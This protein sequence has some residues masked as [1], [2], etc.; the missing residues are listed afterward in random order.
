VVSNKQRAQK[1]LEWKGFNPA[2]VFED[3]STFGSTWTLEAALKHAVK[4]KVR[5]PNSHVSLVFL[6]FSSDHFLFCRN[7]KVNNKC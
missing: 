3:D 7:I 4:K 2:F 1:K 6:T 5:K